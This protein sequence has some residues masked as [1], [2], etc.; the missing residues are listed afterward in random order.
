MHDIYAL[1]LGRTHIVYSPLHHFTAR[2]NKEALLALQR[3]SSGIHGGPLQDLANRIRR[4]AEYPSRPNSKTPSPSKIVIMPTRRCNMRCVYCNFV[5]DQAHSSTLDPIQACHFID[6]A[7]QNLIHNKSDFLHIHFFGGEPFLHHSIVDQIV[8]YARQNCIRNSV[9]L[10]LEVTTNGKF[11]RQY[12]QFVGNVFDTV[13]VSY[14]GSRAFQNANRPNPDGS[15][16][17]KQVSTTLQVLSETSTELCV[18]LCA[19]D[20]SV[21]ALPDLARQITDA[22]NID[23]LNIEPLTANSV[24]NSAGLRPPDPYAHSFKPLSALITKRINMVS[25]LS[26]GLLTS[27]KSAGLPVRSVKIH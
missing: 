3:N 26:M 14:D 6:Y 20:Q 16:S 1:Q 15:G 24:A 21:H 22:Y 27:D 5:T 7:L 23:K 8:H 2:V 17:F 12:A 11:D 18:R 10:R 19:T 9:K 25:K 13:V 4:P